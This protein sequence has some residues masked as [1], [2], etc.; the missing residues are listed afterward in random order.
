VLF[1]GFHLTAAKG[2]HIHSLLE[3]AAGYSDAKE[4][5]VMEHKNVITIITNAHC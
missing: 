3:P 5:S 1:S 4:I 2:L